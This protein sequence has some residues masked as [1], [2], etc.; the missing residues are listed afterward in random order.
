MNHEEQAARRFAAGCNCAQAV[1]A[2]FGDVTGLDET[3]A[4]RLASSMGGG[5]ARLREVCGAVS[6][7]AL[8]AGLL[9]GP[10]D[11][12]DRAAK[13][14]HYARVQALTAAFRAENGSIVCRE[15]LG[16]PGAQ[17]PLPEARTAQYYQKRPCA[18]LVRCAARILDQYLA[19]NPPPD[20]GTNR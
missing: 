1:L 13:A 17:P 19:D 14:A 18:Q 20:R 10:D 9:Y 8:A 6:G 16:V 12:C 5:M 4:L 11:P 2:A 7:M 15:L 3:M